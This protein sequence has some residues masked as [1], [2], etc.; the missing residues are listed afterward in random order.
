MSDKKI[1]V[2]KLEHTNLTNR[3]DLLDWLCSAE[4]KRGK[5]TDRY[6]I[7]DTT[8]NIFNTYNDPDVNYMMAMLRRTLQ[9]GYQSLM[10]MRNGTDYGSNST[11]SGVQ[12][13]FG[14]GE[15]QQTDSAPTGEVRDGEPAVKVPPDS[16]HSGSD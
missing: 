5:S 7:V 2:I 9:A 3:P 11:T 4:V 8:T 15:S 6:W 12:A 16:E 13:D 10:I 1:L 14:P